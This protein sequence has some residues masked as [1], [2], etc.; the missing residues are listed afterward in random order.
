M[1][2]RFKRPAT[3]QARA[4]REQATAA[5]L[6]NLHQQLTEQVLA[7]RS[8]EDWQAWLKVAASFHTYSFRNVMLIMKQRPDAQ[9]V[10]GY[11]A[12][13][14]LG[15]QVNKGEKGIQILAPIMRK[16]TQDE[17]QEQ[18]AG[19]E[20]SETTSG[21]EDKQSPPTRR[22]AGFRLAYVWDIAQT[23]GE[24]L[25]TKPTPQLLVGQAPAKLWDA[26]TEQVSAQGYRVERGDCAQANGFTNFTTRTVRVRD[27]VDPAQAVKTLAHE[28]GHVLLHQPSDTNPTTKG[29]LGIREVEAESVA[30][31]VLTNAGMQVGDYSYPYVASWAEQ[32]GHDSVEDA[33]QAT[34]QRVLRTARQII[35]GLEPV[36]ETTAAKLREVKVDAQLGV[37][38]TEQLR[39]TVASREPKP[40]A[41]TSDERLYAA[42]EAAAAWFQ[43]QLRAP[44]ASTHRDYLA[45]RGI[46]ENTLEIYQVGFAPGSWTGLVTHLRGQGFTDQEIL[47][48]G[49]GWKG[50][51]GNLLASHRDRIMFPIRDVQGRVTGFTGRCAPGVEGEQPKYVNTRATSVFAK[52]EQLLGLHRLNAQRATKPDRLVLC[53]GPL[54]AMAITQATGGTHLGLALAG[55]ALTDKHLAKI[56]A[57]DP[58]SKG[59]LL[60]FDHDRAGRKATQKTW[61]LLNEQQRNTAQ[62]IE[63][64]AGSDPAQLAELRGAASLREA[65]HNPVPL[66]DVMVD[67]IITA[68]TTNVAG[69]QLLIPETRMAAM[70]AVAK[71]VAT[72]PPE[73]ITRHVVRIGQALDMDYG[74]VS[75][76]IADAISPPESDGQTL[77]ERSF[78]R[79]RRNDLDR[80]QGVPVETPA[81]LLETISQTPR[82]DPAALQPDTLTG[83]T[84]PELHTAGGRAAVS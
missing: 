12:W 33:I 53:E 56:A 27:D 32:A 49:L 75:R 13:K 84:A 40:V 46:N 15:R 79:S 1:G 77:Q 48:A 8:G 82:L 14:A 58:T 18:R 38:R 72:R 37:Q 24:P 20:K 41:V 35:E 9:R 73:S 59:L 23:S 68:S 47:D 4:E 81:N 71:F 54:D 6:E 34:G 65:L 22:P 66:E 70:S 7:L 43:T 57:H 51:K 21:G 67:H 83:E 11:E 78:R 50:N 44:E 31:I 63:L 52:S 16:P 29:C 61:A 28:L 80:G 17:E 69:Q 30:F 10:A 19:T 5:K 55:T 36:T 76:A 39:E 45:G 26:L 74:R 2:T 64:P 60:A 42:N 62:A 25:P 3:T